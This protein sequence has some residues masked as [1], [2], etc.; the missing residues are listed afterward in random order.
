MLNANV[1]N[2][3]RW[4]LDTNQPSDV[5]CMEMLPGCPS[6]GFLRFPFASTTPALYKRDMRIILIVSLLLATLITPPLARPVFAQ[7][8]AASTD[9]P[10]VV[11]RFNQ[12][13]VYYDQQLYNA[14]SRAV[15]IKPTVMLELVSF[16]PTSGNRSTNEQL[17][18][19]NLSGVIQSLN[20]MGVP[21]ERIRVVQ[22]NSA[23]IRYHEIHLYVH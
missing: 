18:Q 1:T 9:I 20:K 6:R 4:E 2:K 16:L 8:S 12:R 13:K 22:E 15:A 11:I 17:A 19:R 7:A 21:R 10:L 5:F 23:A 14:V 3:Y